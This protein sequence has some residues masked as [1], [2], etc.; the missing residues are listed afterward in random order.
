MFDMKSLDILKLG[1]NVGSGEGLAMDQLAV[2]ISLVENSLYWLI[3][4][5]VMGTLISYFIIKPVIHWFVL[6]KQDR[7]LSYIM[8]SL[9]IL[10]CVTSVGFIFW[11]SE[12]VYLI[13]ITLLCMAVFGGLLVI[14]RLVH[15]FFQIIFAKKV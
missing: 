5:I 8:C 1:D 9:F 6:M 12:F 14:M 4:L 2:L 10:T 3:A 7:V 11:K 13:K 15:Y